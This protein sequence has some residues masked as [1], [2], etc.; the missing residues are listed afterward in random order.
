MRE[1]S[2]QDVGH[3]L[4]ELFNQRRK[5]LRS[6]YIRFSSKKKASQQFSGMSLNGLQSFANKFGL[7][8][9]ISKTELN[10]VIQLYKSVNILDFYFNMHKT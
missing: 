1:R 4:E 6:I 3:K 7:L 5:E 9:L 8:P 2:S 10:E